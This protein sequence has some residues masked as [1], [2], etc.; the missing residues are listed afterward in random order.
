MAAKGVYF[1]GTSGF[2]YNHWRGTFYP[3]NLPQRTW[4]EH[5]AEH[6]DTVEINSSFYHLPRPTTCENWKAP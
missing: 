4:L 2:T 1:I 3:D 6:F 5:Y